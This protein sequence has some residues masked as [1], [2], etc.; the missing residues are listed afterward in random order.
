MKNKVLALSVI[1]SALALPLAANAGLT[2]SRIDHKGILA[3]PG[4]ESIALSQHAGK[5]ISLNKGYMEVRTERVPLGF[6]LL[7]PQLVLKQNGK[8]YIVEVPTSAYHNEESFT[9]TVKDSGLSHDLYLRKTEVKSKA[10]EL[11]EVQVCT[12]KEWGFQCG[13]DVNGAYNCVQNLMDKTGTQN[14][15]NTYV[16]TTT[17]YKLTLGQ[18]KVLQAEFTSS[19]VKSAKVS[20]EELSACK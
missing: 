12:Y 5:S 20:S 14:A 8:T 2:N 3:I 1:F 6:S 10:K 7:D 4:K 13:V 16:D 17:T 11:V 19:N 18:N 15:R 9:L